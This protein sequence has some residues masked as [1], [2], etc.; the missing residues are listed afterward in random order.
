MNE[1]A[2]E[3]RF[4]SLKDSAIYLGQSLR[5]M[6]RHYI[7]LIRAGVIAYRT[8]KDSL[9]GR[10]MFNKAS[11]DKYMEKCQILPSVVEHKILIT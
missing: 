10:I 9:K 7:D 5:W 1:M 11:L 3:I 2:N 8:P 6:R 4:L